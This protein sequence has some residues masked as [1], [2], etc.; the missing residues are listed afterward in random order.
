MTRIYASFSIS[1]N[2]NMKLHKSLRLRA[3]IMYH[4]HYI[5][6]DNFKILRL[7]RIQ[8]VSLTGKGV[9]PHSSTDGGRHK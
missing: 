8:T 5:P 2:E 9:S 3:P 6:N 7:T 4:K 1:C